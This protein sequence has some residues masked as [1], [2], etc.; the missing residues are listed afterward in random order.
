MTKSSLDLGKSAT[1]ADQAK[2][3]RA[4]MRGKCLKKAVPPSTE[5]EILEMLFY[6]GASRCD[7]KPSRADIEVTKDIKKALAVMGIAPHDHLIVAGT[8]CVSF[9]SLGHL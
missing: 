9:K 8:S 3:H 5:L 6:A 2:G 4:R 7:T 1:P